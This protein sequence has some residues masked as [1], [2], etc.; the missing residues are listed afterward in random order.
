MKI[1]YTTRMTKESNNKR[2]KGKRK[3]H[4]KGRREEIETDE[5]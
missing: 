3:N 4:D 2:K 1:N 5:K